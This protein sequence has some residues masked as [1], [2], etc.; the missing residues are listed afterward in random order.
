MV[1]G[2]LPQ[3]GDLVAVVFTQSFPISTNPTRREKGG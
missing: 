2:L 3:L 1:D